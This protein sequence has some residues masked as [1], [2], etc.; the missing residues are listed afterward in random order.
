M[1]ETGSTFPEKT[2]E[3]T[4]EI[5]GAAKVVAADAAEKTKEGVE[6]VGEKTKEGAEWIEETTQSAAE[7]TGEFYAATKA[8]AAD[9]AE[10]TKEGAEWM[11]QK[12]QKVAEVAHEAADNAY[13]TAKKEAQQVKE[14]SFGN[15]STL[16]SKAG[17]E[18]NGKNISTR[19]MEDMIKLQDDF[20][21]GVTKGEGRSWSLTIQINWYVQFVYKIE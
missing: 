1:Q 11:E 6:W 8:V 12:T 3:K 18:N 13:Q 2:A 14:T 17:S 16:Q 4:G 7:K 21:Q 10:K 19:A 5:Y 20:K 15:T 9:A